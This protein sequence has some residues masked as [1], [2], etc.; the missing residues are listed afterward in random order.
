[1]ADDREQ[2]KKV[3]ELIG[4]GSTRRTRL[5]FLSVLALVGVALQWLVYW[6]A[7]RTAGEE[8]GAVGIQV[9]AFALGAWILTAGMA[10]ALL[11]KRLKDTREG[12]VLEG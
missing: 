11:R 9:W 10:L 1:M 4:E 3:M 6:Y 2:R 12:A 8:W 5:A 7:A